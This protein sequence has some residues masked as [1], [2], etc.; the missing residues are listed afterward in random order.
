MRV[1]DFEEYKSKKEE[2]SEIRKK[3]DNLERHPAEDVLSSDVIMNYQTG[4]GI[5]QTITGVDIAYISRLRS[6]YITQIMR[7]QEEC[8]Q[9]E[10]Y[11]DSIEDSLTRRMVRM[12]FVDGIKQSKIA[13]QLHID[14]SNVSRKLRNFLLSIS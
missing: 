2:I 3:L 8:E 11:I 9:V 1:K 13:F 12:A 10:E 7:L 6:R 14:Q 5:P 4:Y